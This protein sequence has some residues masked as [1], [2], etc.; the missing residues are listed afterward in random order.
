MKK[1]VRRFLKGQELQ[2]VMENLK[3]SLRKFF[4]PTLATCDF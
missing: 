1:E 2:L 3:S 4:I